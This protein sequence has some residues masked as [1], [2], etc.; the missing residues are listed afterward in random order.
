[1][2][3]AAQVAADLP[4]RG[5]DAVYIAAAQV[6]GLRLVTWDV[7]QRT[8]GSSVVPTFTPADLL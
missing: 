2:L 3:L 4:V 6:L 7:E 8:R 5:A 1:M